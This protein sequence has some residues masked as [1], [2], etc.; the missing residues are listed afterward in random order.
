MQQAVILVAGLTL[1]IAGCSLAVAVSGSIIERKRPFT[2][3]RLTGTPVRALYRV[4]LL[5]TLVPLGTATVVA[6]GVGY[7]IALPV[8]RALAP[9][10]HGTPVPGATYYLTLGTGLLLAI[11]VIL[12][13]LPI[14]RR[15]TVTD[16]ARFE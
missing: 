4:V 8:A 13:C 12:T 6:A 7:L 15:S 5:E 9:K 1:L 2:L 3:L 14:L 10:A 16:N 11:A